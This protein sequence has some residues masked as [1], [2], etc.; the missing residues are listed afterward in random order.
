MLRTLFRK[1]ARETADMLDLPGLR[2]HSSKRIK[3]ND[4]MRDILDEYASDRSPESLVQGRASVCQ[5]QI[6]DTKR[7]ILTCD[8]AVSLL[9]TLPLRS[10]SGVRCKNPPVSD[11]VPTGI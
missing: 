9:S 1:R 6:R 10:D 11:W 3:S 4:H 8:E 2:E 5:S 7:R